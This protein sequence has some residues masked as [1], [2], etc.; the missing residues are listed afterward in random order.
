MLRIWAYLFPVDP[1]RGWVSIQRPCAH[2]CLCQV[3]EVSPPPNTI[4]YRISYLYGSV[5]LAFV[6]SLFL[7]EGTN[8]E[9]FFH[10]DYWIASNLAYRELA[11]I[12]SRVVTSVRANVSMQAR[13]LCPYIWLRSWA[14]AEQFA[15][16][17]WQTLSC[18][19]HHVEDYDSFG[20]ALMH[21]YSL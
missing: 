1:L 12:L 9:R 16:C 14:A 8:F 3:S 6:V 17:R 18:I 11:L 4:W 7:V 20:P 5:W 15:G 21:T 13:H 2:S 19:H 10:V